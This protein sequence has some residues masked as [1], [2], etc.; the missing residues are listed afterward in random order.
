[1]CCVLFYQKKKLLQQTLKPRHSYNSASSF[2]LIIRTPRKNLPS[3]TSSDW[4]YKY[5]ESSFSFLF[6]LLMVNLHTCIL[7][8]YQNIQISMEIVRMMHTCTVLGKQKQTIIAWWLLT[9]T[10]HN[11]SYTPNVMIMHNIVYIYCTGDSYNNIGYNTYQYLYELFCFTNEC[12]E[13]SL[14]FLFIMT[15]PLILPRSV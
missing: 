15:W 12:S 14:T 3:L 13:C 8:I 10:K 9:C 4:F 11:V 1:M 5:P 7:C 2:S 6:E